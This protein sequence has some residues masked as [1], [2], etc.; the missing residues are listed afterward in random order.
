[1]IANILLKSSADPSREECLGI[2]RTDSGSDYI[3]PTGID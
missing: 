1:M 2:H 3:A